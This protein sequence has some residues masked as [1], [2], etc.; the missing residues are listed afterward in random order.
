MSNII[1]RLKALSKKITDEDW[2]NE[3]PI[4]YQF[5]LNTAIGAV[6]LAVFALTLYLLYLYWFVIVIVVLSCISGVLT[7]R[8]INRKRL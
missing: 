4:L 3:L 2:K 6:V 5:C 7:L 1:Q 8:L